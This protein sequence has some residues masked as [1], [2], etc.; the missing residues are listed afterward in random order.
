MGPILNGLINLQSVENRLRVVK[1][2]L[3]R[4]R[5]K[6]IFLE[7]Q[8]RTL[9][10][11]MEAKQEEIKLTKVQTDRLELELKSRDE[12]IAKFRAALNLAKTNKEYSAILTELNTSKADNL[13]LENQVLDLM[14]NIEADEAACS[15][16]QE[17]IDA[18]MAKLGDLRKET[19]A[20][21]VGY[22]KE[23]DEIQVE[24]DVAARD[25][26]ADVLEVF[27][28]VAETYDGEAI[29]LA[30]QQNERVQSF[31]CNGCFMGIPAEVVNRL[32]TKDEIIRCTNCTRIL[33][34]KASE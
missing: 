20:Q 28:R 8:L 19:E 33:V 24:W 27:N 16:I 15:Q 2:K 21:A 1:S 13:K 17:Q 34:L 6:V 12:H 29:A 4:A 10:S 3:A 18:E 23:I 5:R 22:Q 9:Q 11:E 26:P 14:K 25:I 32:M 30:D 7:N 31:N